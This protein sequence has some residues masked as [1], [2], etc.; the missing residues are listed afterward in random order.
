MAIHGR[1]RGHASRSMLVVGVLG[2]SLLGGCA[3]VRQAQQPIRNFAAE[4]Q[5][6]AASLAKRIGLAAKKVEDS[7]REANPGLTDEELVDVAQ[8]AADFWK[9]MDQI[10]QQAQ[11][12][13]ELRAQQ[14]ARSLIARSTCYWLEANRLMSEQDRN[15]ALR[16]YIGEQPGVAGEDD[17]KVDEVIDGITAQ[18]DS[19]NARGITDRD[20]MLKD[21]ACSIF[22][23]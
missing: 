3:E 20:A 16:T 15:A 4:Y 21:G 10:N 12:E 1:R 19:M 5:A 7:I 13:A 18:M 6:A 23:P 8:Q 22:S 17:P 2:L 11:Q 14:E 9:A